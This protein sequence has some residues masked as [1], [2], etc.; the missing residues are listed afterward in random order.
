MPDEDLR[1]TPLTR[2]TVYH[3]RLI[4]VESL[5]VRLPDGRTAPREV[6]VHPG[7]A[8]IVAVDERELV[9]LVRQH[10]VAVDQ[11][12][13]ELPAGKMDRP[14]ED[15]FACARRELSE[16]TGLEAERVELLT[17]MIPTPGFCTEC[18]RIFLA[19]GLR[20]RAA[21][22]DTDEFLRVERI[23]LREAVERV[24]SG[25]L[26]DAKTALGL[27]MAWRRLH[28]ECAAPIPS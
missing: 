2:E 1:E 12:L 18:T 15:P 11:V 22:L 5:R 20:Q 3:G 14:G 27:L 19:T 21:H 4:D 6:V 16:E 17:P 23:P 7:G 13:L 26:C 24:M 8:A 9:A 25:E 28:G 10:R